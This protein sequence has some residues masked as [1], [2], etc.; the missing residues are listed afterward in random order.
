MTGVV[1]ALAGLTCADGG[2]VR[3]PWLAPVSV[4]FARDW[5]GT[6]QLR[7]GA[8][9]LTDAVRV[10]GAVTLAARPPRPGAA[11]FS[12]PGGMPTWALVADG[13]RRVTVLREARH[14]RDALPGIWKWEQGRLVVCAARSSDGP[15]PRSFSV[16]PDVYLFTLYPAVRKRAAPAPKPDS[17]PERLKPPRGEAGPG[18]G[19]P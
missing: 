9:V 15:R 5:E 1:L 2:P 11:F 14:V 19:A 16:G 12:G 3:G 13:P 6:C 4:N 18:C 10:G 7:A 8:E 17:P